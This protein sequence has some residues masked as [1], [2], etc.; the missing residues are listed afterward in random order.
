MILA[1]SRFVASTLAV[2]GLLSAAPPAQ[3]R[4]PDY[5]RTPMIFVH[6][7][8][9]S[10][11][12]FESQKMRFTSNGYPESYV[13]VID[14]DSTFATETRDDVLARIDEMIADL[15]QETGRPQVDM[16][17]HSLGTSVMQDYLSTPERAANVAHYVNIDGSTADAPPGG[18]PTLALWAGRGAAGREITGATNVTIPNQTHVETATSAESF[19]EMYRFFTGRRASGRIRRGRPEIGIAGRALNFPVNRGLVG[20][21]IEIY[22]LAA[23]TGQ[24]VSPVPVATFAIDTTGDFGPLTVKR[25]VPY[26]FVRTKPGATPLHYVYEPFVRDDHVIRL[27]DSDALNVLVEKSTR[28]VAAVVIR[29]RALGRSGHRERRDHDQRHQRVQLG[30]LPHRPPRQRH[31]RVRSVLG[32]GDRFERAAPCL[33]RT[34]I[35]HRRRRLHPGE[36]SAGRNR[37]RGHQVAEGRSAWS[38]DRPARPD[39]PFPQLRLPQRRGRRSAERLRTASAVMHTWRTARRP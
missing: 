30:D 22:E 36:H 15:Q 20:A 6:G 27:L 18:V 34:S 32:W 33:L 29:Q 5:G 23:D 8:S 39:R 9:G 19:V 12:Q 7:F 35:H 11:A 4:R 28:H 26:E 1:A 17:G 14:Y 3:A 24:R 31:L 37:D 21:T 38:T 10:G 2:V 16:L 25:G 13:R